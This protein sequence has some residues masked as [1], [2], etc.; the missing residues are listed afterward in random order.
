MA[1]P[2]VSPYAAVG[3]PTAVIPPV[4]P[5]TATAAPSGTP[6]SSGGRWK[7][8]HVAIAAVVGLVLGGVGGYAANG[9]DGTSTVATEATTSVASAP[10]STARATTSTPA[11]STS[12]SVSSTSTT[13][14]AA[15]TAPATTAAATTAAGASGTRAQ[16]VPV[17]TPVTVSTKDANWTVRVVNTDLDASAAVMKTN[18][19]N[20]PAPT[21]VKYVLVTLEATYNGPKDSSSYLID[22]N[23]KAIDA[24]NVETKECSDY[25]AY[26]Y[27][28]NDS[29]KEV[30][31]KGK[32]TIRECFAPAADTVDS[33]VLIVAPS[34]SSTSSR[35]FLAIK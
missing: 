31:Q 34:F 7:G 9:S 6:P 22:L 10:A 27:G 12:A 33:L 11:P 26:S 18:S 17:G 5:V 1:T 16:P 3:P 4:A 23:V 29:F 30:F 20:K 25:G 8:A 21:G 24:S 32:V 2:P 35:S 14:R 15:T 13:V 28:N 19:F